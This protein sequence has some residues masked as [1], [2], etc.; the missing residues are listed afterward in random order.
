MQE[1]IIVLDRGMD[2]AEVAAM[3]GCCIGK[4]V[5]PATAASPAK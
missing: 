3:A 2:V 4:P 1:Q 5:A